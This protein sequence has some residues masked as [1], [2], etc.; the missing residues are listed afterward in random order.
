PIPVVPRICSVFPYTTLFRS[1]IGSI[2]MYISEKASKVYG[3]E[4]VPQAIEDAKENMKLNNVT[5]VAFIQGKSEEK[6]PEL[7]QKGISPDLDRKST[8][9]NSSHVTT[10]YA[11]S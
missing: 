9:L 11:V 2:S 10:S 4:I 7:V 6:M 8:R 3:I 1:G 5:N